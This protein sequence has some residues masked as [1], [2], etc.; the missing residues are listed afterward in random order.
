MIPATRTY[1]PV[2]RLDA[3]FNQMLGEIAPNG[4]SHA[5]MAMWADEDHFW[6]EAELPGVADADVDITVHKDIL[7]IRAERKP[8]EDRAYLF[9]NRGFGKFERS[10]RLPEPVN[11]EGV[12]A[13]L[14]DGMLTIE[15]PKSAEAK[16]RKITLR[17][18]EVTQQ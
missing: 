2:N 17:N 16:P 11:A 10:V 12:Q 7:T 5:P 1:V 6:V 4:Q 18:N 13:T 14:K 8:V 15:L 9:N 3:L